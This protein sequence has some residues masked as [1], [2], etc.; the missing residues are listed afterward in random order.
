[1]ALGSDGWGASLFGFVVYLQSE[2]V[3]GELAPCE[4]VTIQISELFHR[5]G[6]IG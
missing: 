4:N 1:M 3:R 6:V 5:V 2:L